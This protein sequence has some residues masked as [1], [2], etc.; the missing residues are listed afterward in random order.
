MT[1]IVAV[2]SFRGGTGKSN[3]TANVAGQLAEAGRRVGVIDTDIQSPGIHVLFGFGDEARPDHTLNEFLDGTAAITD[4]ATD[5]TDRLP[6]DPKGRLL[7]VP[8]SVKP[9]DITAILQSGY[10]VERL[11]DALLELGSAYDLDVLLIDTHPGLN[12]ETLLTS[13]ICD[14]LVV[15]L[16]P[17][18]QDYQ[19][20]AVTLDVAARLGVPDR[21]LIVNKIYAGIDPEIVVERVRTAYGLP[22]VAALPLSEDVA[23]NAS[24]GL[25][26]LSHP[27]HPWSR[28]V[29]ALAARLTATR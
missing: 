26:S 3:I 5:V 25:F 2:H 6:G 11:N 27:D 18:N 21:V 17:D 19:G 22:V 13:A 7:L 29:A 10:D 24:S 16:R 9:Q 12:E 8:S 28:G 1:M 23:G 4:V 14:V 20:T 15:I